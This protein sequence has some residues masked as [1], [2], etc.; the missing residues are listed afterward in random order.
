V[1]GLVADVAVELPV[2]W[3]R[4]F[5]LSNLGLSIVG[6]DLLGGAETEFSNFLIEDDM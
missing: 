5:N 6:F 1:V 3:V 4:D 2:V